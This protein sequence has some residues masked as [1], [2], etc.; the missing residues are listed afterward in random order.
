MAAERMQF[1]VSIS[2]ILRAYKTDKVSAHSHIY[3]KS[4]ERAECGDFQ[5]HC[6]HSRVFLFGRLIYIWRAI[7]CSWWVGDDLFRGVVLTLDPLRL[8]QEA[9]GEREHAAAGPIVVICWR[10]GGCLLPTHSRIHLLYMY[11][12]S[13][14]RAR[15]CSKPEREWYIYMCA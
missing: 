9:A 11:V 2:H 3:N 10:G 7:F 4:A 15:E 5:Q 12:R 1:A 14:M 6:L 13:H 8:L